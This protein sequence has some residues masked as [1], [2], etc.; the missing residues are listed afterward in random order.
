MGS[1]P[2]TGGV[3]SDDMED[4]SILDVNVI[5]KPGEV[6]NLSEHLSSNELLDVYNK[7]NRLRF[8]LNATRIWTHPYRY[9]MMMVGLNELNKSIRRLLS[10]K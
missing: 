2:K 6:I 4:W 10:C 5:D 8:R 7:F 3:V 9:R 1:T